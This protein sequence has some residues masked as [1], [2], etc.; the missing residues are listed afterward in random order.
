MK[1]CINCLLMIDEQES[2]CPHCGYADSEHPID[3]C[4]LPPRTLLSGRYIVGRPLGCGGFGVTYIAWDIKM[5]RRV[6]IKEY[7]PGELAS[8]TAGSRIIEIRPGCEDIYRNGKQSFVN[9]SM[10]LARMGGITGVVPIYDC[11]EDE[12][13]AYIVMEYL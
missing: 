3:F 4:H 9:E 10:R 2:R 6:A 7:M 12:Y 5:S 13:T 8:R 11:F 1:M